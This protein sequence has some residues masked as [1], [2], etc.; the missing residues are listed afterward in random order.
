MNCMG[1]VMKWCRKCEVFAQATVFWAGKELQWG[2][3]TWVAHLEGCGPIPGI[4]VWK[5]VYSGGNGLLQQMAGAYALPNEETATV[6]GVLV[7][8]VF[9]HF[10]V[11]L[12]L[13]SN[14]GRNFEWSLFQSP[15]I[16]SLSC[17]IT[18]SVYPRCSGWDV[19]T[20]ALAVLLVVPLYPILPP[21]KP[22]FY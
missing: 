7:K 19:L 18:R 21:W 15:F 11:L 5:L 6:P 1:D 16:H 17:D 20:L 2:S 22:A 8:E 4:R 3:K 10:G 12:K 14:Q 13:Q 9:N